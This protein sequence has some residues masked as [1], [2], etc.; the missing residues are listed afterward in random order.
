MAADHALDFLAQEYEQWGVSKLHNKTLDP[1]LVKPGDI[2]FVKTDFVYNGTFQERYLPWIKNP[3]ILITGNSSYEVSKGSL[4]KSI[5][6]NP[7]VIKWYCTNAPVGVSDKIIPLPIGFEEPDREGGQQKVLYDMR[8]GRTSFNEKKDKILL[9]YHDLSTN[10]KRAELVN[11]LKGLPF[12]ETQEEKLFFV[13]YLA[14]VNEYKFVIC[15][16][17]SGPDVHRNY[18]A[19]LVDTIPINTKNIIEFLF[20]SHQ[21]PG[22]FI[23]SWDDLTAESFEKMLNKSYNMEAVSLFLEIQHHIQDIK[24]MCVIF[25][26]NLKNT[27][28]FIWDS[29]GVLKKK[30]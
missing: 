21:L 8:A 3:F 11:K 22:E 25:L 2:V 4:I 10:P 18:E 17:G 14:K 6:E 28:D 27:D 30:R 19:L 7:Y 1:E 29:S 16:E 12:V 5:V 15:L 13:D 24:N 23:D 26:N 20:S 9:P